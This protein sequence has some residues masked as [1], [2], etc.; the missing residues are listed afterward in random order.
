MIVTSS[1]WF[2]NKTIESG[3]YMSAKTKKCIEIT[4]NQGAQA[5]LITSAHNKF[6][7]SGFTGTTATVLV[8]KSKQYVMV[9]F[10]YID[11]AKSQCK[12]SIVR[13]IDDNYTVIDCINDIVFNE[14][15]ET[16]G[17]EEDQMTVSEHKLFK[18]S[19]K[20]NL[21]GLNF[22]ELRLIKLPEEIEIMQRAADIADEAIGYI[23][24]VI[25]PGMTETEVDLLLYNKIRQLG[26]KSFSFNTIV[27]SGWRGAMPHGVASNKVIEE[28]DFVTIDFG[29]V[30][31]GYCSDLT[32]TF[33]MSQKVD[34]QLIEIY[35]IVLKAQVSALEA[36]KPN[37]ATKDIDKI[38]R[39]IIS[40]AGY[41][42]YFQHGTG[43][44]LG[45]LIHEA[46]RLNQLSMEVL[47][48]GMVVTIEPGIYVPGLGGVR[49]EDDILITKDGC[50]RL[51]KSDKQLKYIR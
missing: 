18:A 16:I 3:E 17:F 36:C 28:K 13:L 24:T 22:S 43:H 47:K 32:R 11:Q 23:M 6:Y 41:G 48:E 14:Q 15:I 7:L 9:D 20:A 46:P 42:P 34:P 29:A 45:V 49:I 25:Q 30:Y 2:Y 39:D 1:I 12:D 40:D 44:G 4:Q 21:V 51:T 10:R 8:T 37:V 26:A 33:A 5:A 50:I 31:E 27:A 19:L 38:A 35:E